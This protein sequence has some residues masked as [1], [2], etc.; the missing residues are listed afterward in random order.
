MLELFRSSK[1]RVDAFHHVVRDVIGYKFVV[2]ARRAARFTGLLDSMSLALGPVVRPWLKSLYQ[3][4]L[5]AVSWD[6]HFQ[7]S[8]DAQGEVVF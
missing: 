6:G 5:Q 4:I 7:L 1:R 2:S 3:D 8:V